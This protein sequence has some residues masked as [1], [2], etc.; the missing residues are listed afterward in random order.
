MDFVGCIIRG[1]RCIDVCACVVAGRTSEHEK[2]IHILMKQSGQVGE[3][4]GELSL[5]RTTGVMLPN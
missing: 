2:S 5:R 3:G 1:C 4:E